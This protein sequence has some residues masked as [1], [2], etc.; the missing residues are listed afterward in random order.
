MSLALSV[1][2]SAYKMFVNDAFP[3]TDGFELVWR[4]GDMT[5]AAKGGLKCVAESAE[6]VAGHPTPANVS[7]LTWLYE[8]ARA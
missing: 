2:V 3:F 7:T 1:E 5:T 8:F 6:H 4:N